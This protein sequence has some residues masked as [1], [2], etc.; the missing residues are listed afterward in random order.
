M[1]NFCSSSGKLKYLTL[2][3]RRQ[4]PKINE[5]NIIRIEVTLEY[6]NLLFYFAKPEKP[7]LLLQCLLSVRLCAQCAPHRSC[8]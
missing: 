5:K 7:L 4:N 6:Y 2:T 8:P 1:E 3:Y